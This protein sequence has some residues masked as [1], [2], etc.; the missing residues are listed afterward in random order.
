M[1]Q[2][3]HLNLPPEVGLYNRVDDIHVVCVKK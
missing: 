3:E 1:M 2:Y